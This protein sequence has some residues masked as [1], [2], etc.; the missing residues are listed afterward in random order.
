MADCHDHDHY[1]AIEDYYNQ[2]VTAVSVAT[3]MC[4]PPAIAG[5]KKRVPGWSDYV[6]DKYDIA[7]DAHMNWLSI[8]KPSTSCLTSSILLNTVGNLV[9]KWFFHTDIRFLYSIAYFG[10]ILSGLTM[11]FALDTLPKFV[12]MVRVKQTPS[13]GQKYIY[14]YEIPA[15]NTRTE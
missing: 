11:C 14:I 3:T 1:L 2:T 8:G 9:L 13:I 7:K 12:R 6:K 15:Y 4:V 5:S 10:G